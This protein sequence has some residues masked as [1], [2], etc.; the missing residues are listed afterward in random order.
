MIFINVTAIV[1][2]NNMCIGCG[3]C[4]GLCPASALTIDFNDYGEYNAVLQG[5]CLEKCHLCLDV[6]PFNNN[7]NL[8]KYQIVDSIKGLRN[9][10]GSAYYPVEMSAVIKR[11]LDE[12]GKYAVVALPC[13]LKALELA[14][15]REN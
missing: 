3:V 6:C 13:F 2:K 15:N 7:E 10:S 4:A 14:K 12:K 11:V 1:V 5:K 8:F 9:G